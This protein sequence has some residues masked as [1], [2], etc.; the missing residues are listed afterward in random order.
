MN[1]TGI[2]LE[3]TSYCGTVTFPFH[4]FGVVLLLRRKQQKADGNRER[5]RDKAGGGGAVGVGGTAVVE[6]WR[7]RTFK[8][9]KER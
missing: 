6:G 2:N 5:R 4:F 3:C 7:D 1:S 8:Q 9:A